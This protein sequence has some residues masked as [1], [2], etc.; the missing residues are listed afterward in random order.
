MVENRTVYLL[1]WTVYDPT[2]PAGPTEVKLVTVRVSNRGYNHPTAPGPYPA[3]LLEGF[4]FRRQIT[5]DGNTYGASQ[6]SWGEMGLINDDG[7]YNWL[8]LNECASDARQARLLRGRSPDDPYDTFEVLFQG[9]VEQFWMTDGMVRLRWRDRFAEIVDKYVQTRK[10][11]GTATASG[12]LGGD[13]S[14]KDRH[15][16]VVYS[17]AYNVPLSLVNPAFLIYQATD[18][19]AKLIAPNTAV[20]DGGVPISAGIKRET[21]DDLVTSSPEAG[22]YDYAYSNTGL[23]VRLQTTPKRQVTA[24][25]WETFDPDIHTTPEQQDYFG[26]TADKIFNRILRDRAGLNGPNDIGVIDTFTQTFSGMFYGENPVTIRTALDELSQTVGAWYGLDRQGRWTLRRINTPDTGTSVLRFQ[27]YLHDTA[28]VVT[29]DCPI[30]SFDFEEDTSDQNG[31]PVSLVRVA[32]DRNITVQDDGDLGGDKSSPTDP[33]KAP[34]TYSYTVQA[35]E[36]LRNEW[37][38]V[39]SQTNLPD[40]QAIKAKH[41][42]AK[43]WEMTCLFATLG[44]AFIEA[45]RQFNF[46]RNIP[47]VGT[48]VAPL[49]AKTSI[50]DLGDVVEIKYPSVGLTDFKKFLITSIDFNGADDIITLRVRR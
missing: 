27:P 46:R 22:K 45:E 13:P 25:V 21:P 28:A 11:E 43:E 3:R 12:G 48:L 37:R 24:D 18:K 40:R 9:Q 4:S 8:Y 42:T 33:V 17:I 14:M 19:Y 50:L 20:R 49:N 38:Y 5:Q 6:M 44:D 16:P 10:F 7:Y 36:W 15:V 30:I 39:T 34:F 41:P 32:Y 47:R 2:R 1:E 35:R 23:F 31:V 26:Q 29:T